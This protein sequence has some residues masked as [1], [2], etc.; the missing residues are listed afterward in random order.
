MISASARGTISFRKWFLS[1]G[2]TI[3]GTRTK[4]AP[5][6]LNLSKDLV[7]DR[8][9]A[10]ALGVELRRAGYSEEAIQDHLGEEAYSHDRGDGP[11]DD[12]RLPETPIGTL[13]RSFFLQIP[14]SR[15]DLARA[16]GRRG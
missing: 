8:R 4:I 9:A 7:P 15:G 2:T 16:L 11:A 6:R 5:F 12:R 3:L 10:G 1:R 14:V 13:I